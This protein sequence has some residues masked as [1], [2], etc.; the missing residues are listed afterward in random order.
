MA[1]DGK[2][3]ERKLQEGLQRFTE[4]RPSFFHRFYDTRSARGLLPAQPGDF[5]WLLPG[6]PAIL[7]EA[8]S[9]EEGT[10]LRDLIDPA[11]V[12]KHRLWRRAGH[13]T[14]LVYLQLDKDELQWVP[15]DKVSEKTIL[16]SVWSGSLDDID[17]MLDCVHNFLCRLNFHGNNKS[18][19]SFS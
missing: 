16:P 10:P 3:L 17:E 9:T 7:I 2:L 5:F 8:K 15:S 6:I 14:Y 11:Q 13:L 18:K 1:N 4:Q 12:G 19:P